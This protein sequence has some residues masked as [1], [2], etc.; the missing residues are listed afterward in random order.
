MKDGYEPKKPF[1][2]FFA[3]FDILFYKTSKFEAKKVGHFFGS[4]KFK[5]PIKNNGEENLKY[6]L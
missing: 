6:L 5:L 1:I 2:C 4:Y 3:N